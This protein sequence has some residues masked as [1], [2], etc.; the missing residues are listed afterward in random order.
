MKPAWPR[1][2][3]P[4]KPV[5]SIRANA[6]TRARKTWLERSRRKGEAKKGKAASA[7]AS[8]MRKSR[9]ALVSTNE[10]S[11][12]YDVLKYPLA[13]GI[14]HP[15]QLLLG[16]EEAPGPDEEHDEEHYEGGRLAR[17]GAD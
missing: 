12:R 3:C 1:D 15:L 4:A 9:R 17:L 16:S 11:R 6:P 14:L 8:R 2:I 13:N 5:R 10:R 7:V